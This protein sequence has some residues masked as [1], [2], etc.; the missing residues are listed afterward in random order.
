[1]SAGRLIAL[2][3]GSAGGDDRHAP[4]RYAEFDVSLTVDSIDVAHN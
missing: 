3:P 2:L 4:I 1:M